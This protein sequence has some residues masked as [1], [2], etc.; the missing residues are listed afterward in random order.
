MTLLKRRRWTC[1][2]VA[3]TAVAAMGTV[4][5]S[6]AF[7]TTTN[8]QQQAGDGCVSRTDMVEKA[9]IV[10]RQDRT[11]P[12]TSSGDIATFRDDLYNSDGRRIGVSKGTALMY[13]LPTDILQMIDGYDIYGDGVVYVAGASSITAALRG[14]IVTISATGVSGRYRGKVGVR[15]FQLI[16]QEPDHNVYRSS[17][18]VCPPTPP[19]AGAA[20]LF[21]GAGK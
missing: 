2:A 16:G 14:E 21:A 20:D 19:P 12:G 18:T 13:I 3:A 10:K 9:F 11:L 1:V 6:N 4:Q 17:L 8:R 15:T 7:A 5:A